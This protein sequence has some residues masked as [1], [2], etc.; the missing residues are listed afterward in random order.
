MAK[1]PPYHTDFEE[2]PAESRKVYH[3]HNNCPDGRLI[4]PHHRKSGTGGKPLCK[5]CAKMS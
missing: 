1:V 2:H 4:L 3:D 5:K